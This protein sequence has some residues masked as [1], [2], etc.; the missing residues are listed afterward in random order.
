MISPP[1]DKSGVLFALDSIE[2]VLYRNSWLRIV[3][4]D[5]PRSS[6]FWGR[7]YPGSPDA[8]IGFCTIPY[9]RQWMNRSIQIVRSPND[10]IFSNPSDDLRWVPLDP[11]GT[12]GVAFGFGGSIAN[13]L[14]RDYDPEAAD[15]DAPF[16]HTH[17][18]VASHVYYAQTA[19]ARYLDGATDVDSLLVEEVSLEILQRVVHETYRV[20]RPRR[21]RPQVL[22]QRRQRAA[23]HDAIAYLTLRCCEK[24]SLLD[25]ANVTDLSPP[26]LCRVFRRTTGSTVHSYLTRLRLRVALSRLAD[27]SNLTQ[28]ALEHGFCDAAHFTGAF[29]REFGLPPSTSRRMLRRADLQQARKILQVSDDLLS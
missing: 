27:T 23:V 14:V 24:L 15:G 5:I 3:R 18:P 7:E 2:T 8:A 11:R 20:Q 29:R 13:D 12:T 1:R 26:Y 19:L 21:K 10:V 4:F 28:L 22:A 17:A 9:R 16:R 6:E 25:V